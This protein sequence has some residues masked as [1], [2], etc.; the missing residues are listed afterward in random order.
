M[1]N[2]T[3]RELNSFFSNAT[4]YIVIVIF[5]LSTS[6]LLW[7]FPGDY[8]ILDMGYANI[9][10]LFTLTPWLYLFLCPAVTM[11]MFAEEKQSGT[12]ELLLTRP[13]SPWKIVCGKAL[14][15][16]L[17]VIIA[18]LPTLIWA[19]SVYYISDPVGNLDMGA[20]WGSWLGL[21][22]LAM[23]YVCIGLF[24]SSIS[25]NQIVAF[26]ISA[27]LCFVLF[28]GFELLGSLFSGDI[29]YILK[30]IGIRQH[31]LSIS[32][33]VIDSRDL[34]YFIFGSSIFLYITK[35]IITKK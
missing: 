8:N 4:G 32:R 9:G 3:S 12:I 23:V 20:F 28:Y 19:L 11:K 24:G 17:L 26:I 30:N 16:W 29:A 6:L 25:K 22:F 27:L 10:G 15:G 5:L 1:W 2:I 14:A 7:V 31:C 18:L 21:V 13:I 35:L 33:G 34:L